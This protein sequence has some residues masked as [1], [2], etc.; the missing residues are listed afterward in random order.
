MAWGGVVAATA[1][2]EQKQRRD[3]ESRDAPRESYLMAGGAAGGFAGHCGPSAGYGGIASV[4]P[5]HRGLPRYWRPLWI[6]RSV[7]SPTLLRERAGVRMES[8]MTQ[9]SLTNG[10]APTLTIPRQSKDPCPRA[11]GSRGRRAGGR[12]DGRQSG[13][14]HPA[15]GGGRS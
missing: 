11:A 1:G 7:N 5:H 12:M 10:D 8:W 14:L 3:Q 4:C 15:L 6:V 13:R 9:C 2:G